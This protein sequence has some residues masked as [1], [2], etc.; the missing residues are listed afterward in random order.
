MARS[1]LRLSPG[2]CLLFI[3]LVAS[4]S[5][6]EEEASQKIL[7]FASYNPGSPWTDSVGNEIKDQLSIY[8]PGAEFSFEYMD[9]KRQEP[10][11][12]RLNKLKNLY[13]NKYKDRHY[14]VITCLDDDAFQ[15]LLNNR[16]EL[17]S[18]TTVVFCGVD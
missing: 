6:L 1:L 15:F 18:S 4:S 7:I 10:T 16:D 17:F 11:E 13:K 2:L 9:T 3:T 14:D 5:A 12:A 8:Y